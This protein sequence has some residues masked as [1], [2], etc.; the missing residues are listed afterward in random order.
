VRKPVTGAPFDEDASVDELR[1][2]VEHMYGEPARF[3]EAVEDEERF[4]GEVVGWA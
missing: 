1:E 4:N 3:V 2:A